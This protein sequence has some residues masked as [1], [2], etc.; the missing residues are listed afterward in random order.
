[1][2]P[3]VIDIL[4][5]ASFAL[6]AISFAVR[7]M[8]LLRALAISSGIVGM[9]YNFLI[10]AGPLWLV[11]VWLGIFATINGVRIAGLFNERLGVSFNDEERELHETLF[12]GFAPVEFMKLM[13]I[14]HWR[15][16]AP[17]ERLADEGVPVGELTLIYNGEVAIERDGQEVD[18][19]RDGALIG[20]IS[21]IQGGA[22]TATVNVIR[23]SRLVV[24][25]KAEVQGLLR[26]NP[27]MDVAMQGVFSQDLT[28]KL[29]RK[30]SGT[31]VPNFDDDD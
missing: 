13:R 10:P 3:T 28:R 15:D 20:E 23:A 5:H 2:T 26:R 12:R 21:F 19:S 22:A 24:W 7:D 16:A 17:G 1:M 31:P 27:T 9:G 18:R 6:M 25:T 4:G 30:T 14:A 29:V 11:I 8:I